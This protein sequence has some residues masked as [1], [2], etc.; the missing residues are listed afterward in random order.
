MIW[1]WYGLSPGG[2]GA[3]WSVGAGPY[4]PGGAGDG[5]GVG[6]IPGIGGRG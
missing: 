5:A 6:T 1:L 2:G 3:P 4:G